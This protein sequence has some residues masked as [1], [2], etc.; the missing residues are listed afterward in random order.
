MAEMLGEIGGAMLPEAPFWGCGVVEISMVF[1]KPCYVICLRC[2]S[3]NIAE[4]DHL[5]TVYLQV[6]V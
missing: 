1:D 3:I 4:Y 6:C 2:N 5:M